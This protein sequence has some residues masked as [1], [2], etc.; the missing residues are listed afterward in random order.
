MPPL[1]STLLSTALQRVGELLAAE[2]R[3]YSVTLIGGAA[4]SLQGLVSRTTED[5]DILTFATDDTP[6]KLLESPDPLPQPLEV[7]VARVGRDLGLSGSWLNHRAAPQWKQGLPPGFSDRLTWHAYAALRVGLASRVDLIAFKLFAI[8]DRGGPKGGTVDERD[9]VL[10]APTRAEL[11]TAGEWVRTQ[12]AGAEFPRQ[13]QEV[14][15]RV[16]RQGR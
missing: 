9:L 6:P 8:M 5:A 10:L 4:L 14:M 12:D 15:E 13:L 3:R 11:E 16:A 7:A 2:G 1:S